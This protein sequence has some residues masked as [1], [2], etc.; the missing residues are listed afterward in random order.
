MAKPSFVKVMLATC[1]FAVVFLSHE[2]KSSTNENTRRT[3]STRASYNTAESNAKNDRM[4]MYRTRYKYQPPKSNQDED[5]DTFC[6]SS[7]N[8]DAYFGKGNSKERST[9]NE[10]FDIYNLFFKDLITTKDSK[11][12][13]VEMGAYNGIQESNSRFFDKCLGWD[14]LLVEGNPMMWDQLVP[15]RPNAHRFS[16][17]P[18]CSEEEEAANTTVKFDKYPMTN[19]GLHHDSVETSYSAKNHTVDVPCGSLTNVLL[20]VFPNGHVSFFSLDVEGAE[21]LIVR[22]IDFSKVF[23]EVMIIENRNSFCKRNCKSRDEFR[24]VMSEAGYVLF[25]KVITRSD[26]FIHPLSKH[27]E[28]MNARLQ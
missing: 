2:F 23:I 22:N 28:T 27:L 15:N 25:K 20:D 13:V 24:K 16:F 12:S 9:N 14:T 8:Y 6:G 3:S 7:P 17:A 1:A 4:E 19:A 10:D 21:P 11:G 18:S 5:N 26:L